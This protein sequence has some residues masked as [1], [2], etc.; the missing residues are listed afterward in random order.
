MINAFISMHY[1]E[2]C[3]NINTTQCSQIIAEHPESHYIAWKPQSSTL[4]GSLYTLNA[5]LQLPLLLWIAMPMQSFMSPWNTLAISIMRA[6]V[7]TL[8]GN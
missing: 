4:Q 7:W 5:Q 3:S 8:I 6:L 1:N 2:T